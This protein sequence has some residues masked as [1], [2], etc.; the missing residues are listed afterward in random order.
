MAEPSALR[1]WQGRLTYLVLA[2]AIILLRLLPLNTIPPGPVVPP[3]LLLLIT[4]VWVTRRPDYTP[5]WTIAV[6]FLLADLLFQNP[7]GLEVALVI[8]LTEAL[9]RRAARLREAPFWIE[10]MTVTFGIVLLVFARRAVLVLFAVPQAGLPAQL[11]QM[12]MTILCYPLAVGIMYLVF[13]L[14]RPAAGE[15]NAMGQRL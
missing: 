12:V 3:D 15:V 14:R 11:S 1:G 8:A 4:L 9:R 7:P 10:W 5:V 13:G 6:L 2:L